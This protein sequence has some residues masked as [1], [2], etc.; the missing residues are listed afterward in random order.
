[1]TEVPDAPGLGVAEDA[2]EPG[3]AP[4]PEPEPDA[5]GLEDEV[6]DPEEEPDVPGPPADVVPLAAVRRCGAASL[7]AVSSGIA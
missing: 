4:E 5:A 2:P 3:E 6:P 7:R 1:V